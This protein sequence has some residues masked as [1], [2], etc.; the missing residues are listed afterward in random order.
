MSPPMPTCGLRAAEQTKR[1]KMHARL[2]TCTSAN[3]QSYC[4]TMAIFAPQKVHLCG[5]NLKQVLWCVA[6]FQH[7][8]HT[9]TMHPIRCF[10]NEAVWQP[11]AH[12]PQ[13][14]PGFPIQRLR[15]M[16]SGHN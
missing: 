14:P 9:R 12:R 7:Q 8:A 3:Q 11:G 5:P 2:F 4:A 13:G 1:S 10:A 6:C 16:M 15:R